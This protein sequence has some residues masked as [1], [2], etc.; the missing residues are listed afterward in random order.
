L[1][2]LEITMLQ[3]ET[4]SARQRYVRDAVKNDLAVL[5]DF[6]VGSFRRSTMISPLST[7]EG[8]FPI[9]LELDRHEVPGAGVSA[10]RLDTLARSPFPYVA[11]TRS[12]RG[13]GFSL[14]GQ[15]TSSALRK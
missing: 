15:T 11:L 2:N 8:A 13:G 6:L 4:V 9:G 7:A 1:K 12:E 14:R 10:L 5:D 3:A